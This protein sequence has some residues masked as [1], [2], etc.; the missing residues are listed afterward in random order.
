[1]KNNV[2]DTATV[3]VY[4]TRTWKIDFMIKKGTQVKSSKKK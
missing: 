2:Y 3:M 4:Y 1:M